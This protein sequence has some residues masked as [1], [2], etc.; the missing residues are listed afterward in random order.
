MKS[1]LFVLK[2]NLENLYRIKSIT[3]YELKSDVRDTKLGFLWNILNPT[4]Q[5]FTFWIVFG[6]GIRSGKDVG[7]I[8]FLPWMIPPTTRYSTALMQFSQ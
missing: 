1:I 7:G 4:I 2:E 8:A 6:I 5:I 3:K